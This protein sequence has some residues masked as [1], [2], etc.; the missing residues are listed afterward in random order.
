V[1]RLVKFLRKR[2]KCVE[3][4]DGSLIKELRSSPARSP[5]QAFPELPRAEEGR[6]WSPGTPAWL[7]KRTRRDVLH[8]EYSV[9]GPKTQNAGQHVKHS[10][11]QG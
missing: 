9:L 2:I 8:T 1:S 7:S 5:T 4:V 3:Q 6:M 10:G 11:D